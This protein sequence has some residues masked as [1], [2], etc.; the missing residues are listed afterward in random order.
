MKQVLL[1]TSCL[2]LSAL[3]SVAFSGEDGPSEA[4]S[5][6]TRSDSCEDITQPADLSQ[7]PNVSTVYPTADILPENLLRFYIYFDQA[8]NT[9]DTLSH[10]ALLDAQGEHLPGVFLENKVQLWSPDRTRL[11][12]LF[13]PGRVKTGLVA[14]N[15][16]GRALNAGES[17]TL[18]V[19]P[20]AINGLECGTIYRKNFKVSA[21][22]YKQPKLESWLLSQPKTGTT[23]TLKVSFDGPIDHT[24][25]A[26]RIRVKDGQRQIVPG[27]IDLGPSETTWLFS[28]K[29][30]W[31]QDQSYTLSVNPVLEDIVGNRITGLFDQPNLVTESA[32]AEQ[33]HHLK[34]RLAP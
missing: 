2:L 21:A 8:M 34:I 31:Q 16:M 12:L 33:L 32:S 17:Y 30:P 24:S 6:E 22:D 25:L 13:D 23:E 20:A 11:T 15:T 9:E 7:L 18:Q 29:T 28:P 3:P 10:I 1:A 5:K 26:F 27:A 19:A 14:H 4:L